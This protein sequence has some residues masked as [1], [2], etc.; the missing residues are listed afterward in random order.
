MGKYKNTLADGRYAVYLGD[1]ILAQNELVGDMLFQY[2]PDTHMYQ[3][4]GQE[5]IGYPEEL[6]LCDELFVP[7]TVTGGVIELQK[8]GSVTG[9]GCINDL[10]EG[11]YINGA[12]EGNC[13]NDIEEDGSCD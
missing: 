12:E 6:V 10:E 3:L 5:G 9:Y 11:N 8:K 4:T 13:I 2:N 7:Y 1:T